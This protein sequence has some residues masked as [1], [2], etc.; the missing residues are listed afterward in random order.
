M[1]PRLMGINTVL[2]LTNNLEKARLVTDATLKAALRQLGKAADWRRY[3][4]GAGCR[5][6]G[7]TAAY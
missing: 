4:F 1:K 3:W 7:F 2:L 6:C 5:D